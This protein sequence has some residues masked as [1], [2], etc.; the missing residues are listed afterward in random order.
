M[1]SVILALVGAFIVL[2]F[3]YWGTR[4]RK[5]LTYTVAFVFAFMCFAFTFYAAG[6]ENGLYDPTLYHQMD[7][8][9]RPL[10]DWLNS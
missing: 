2:P 1:K 10:L 5:R 4:Y 3:F 6:V 9:M 7:A 8:L